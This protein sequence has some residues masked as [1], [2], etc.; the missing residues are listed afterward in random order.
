MNDS[1]WNSCIDFKRNEIVFENRNKL[2]GAYVIRHEY[3]RNILLAF[4]TACF[5]TGAMLA[6]FIIKS[7][8][9]KSI[10]ISE[11]FSETINL[12]IFAP[13][14]VE[15]IPPSITP[16]ASS[17]PITKEFTT[18]VV[19]N[20]RIEITD[21]PMTPENTSAD[22]SNGGEINSTTLTGIS[23]TDIP[24]IMADNDVKNWAEIMPAFPGGYKELISYLSTHIRY[25]SKALANNI[26][27]TVYVSFVVDTSGMIRNIQLMRGI[28]QECDLEAIK[29]VKNMPKWIPGSQNGNKVSVEMSLPV[30]FT[31]K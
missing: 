30:R 17:S 23:M 18:P 16:Q 12:E 31:I 27:G 14:P 20:D 3:P 25:P 11:K 22:L 1:N 9:N 26:E 5:F 13:P 21:A 2:F 15:L 24:E 19:V 10:V 29:A 6:P 4:I 8:H 28:F 7:L